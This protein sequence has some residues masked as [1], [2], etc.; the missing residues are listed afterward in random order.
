MMQP[1]RLTYDDTPAVI[2]VPKD[3]QHQRVEIIFW[4]LEEVDSTSQTVR[5]KPPVELKGKV[6]ELGDVMH[7]VPPENWGV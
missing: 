3:L 7:S 4:P 1:R 6:R 2:P 5:R